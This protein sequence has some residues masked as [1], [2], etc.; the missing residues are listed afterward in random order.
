MNW[1]ISFRNL[2]HHRISSVWWK[3]VLIII[4]FIR[5]LFSPYFIKSILSSQFRQKLCLCKSVI[6]RDFR[7]TYI[8]KDAIVLI[9]NWLTQVY[10]YISLAIRIQSHANTV[11][12]YSY[13]IGS[14]TTTHKHM[15]CLIGHT[16]PITYVHCA[17]SS[18]V[19]TYKTHIKTYT[20]NS[21]VHAYINT[22]PIFDPT[23]ASLGHGQWPHKISP[24][25]HTTEEICN[26]TIATKTTHTNSSQKYNIVLLESVRGSSC[27]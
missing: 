25:N 24:P 18:L 5:Y 11:S 23:F 15:L 27:L 16:L 12:L 26:T 10:A 7:K 1:N 14:H 6:P 20:H 19:H 13:L 17:H 4:V 21:F 2:H 8:R 3:L 9:S 22:V